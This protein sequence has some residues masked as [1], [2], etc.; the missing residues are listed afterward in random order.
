MTYPHGLEKDVSDKRKSLRK[1][2]ST[3]LVAKSGKI[4]KTS[5]KTIGVSKNKATFAAEKGKTATLKRH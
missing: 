5:R 2:P 1:H 3:N 4:H